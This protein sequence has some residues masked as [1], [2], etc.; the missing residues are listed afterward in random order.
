MFEIASWVH[1]NC[2]MVFHNSENIYTCREVR[3]PKEEARNTAL[4]SS[5][6]PATV[7]WLATTVLV[8]ET[9]ILKKA[10]RQWAWKMLL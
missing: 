3:S 9:I 1:T 6:Q 5:W 8:E 7:L 2:I 10:A 4:I